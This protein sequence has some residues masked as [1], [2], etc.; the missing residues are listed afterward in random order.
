MHFYGGKATIIILRWNLFVS[1]VIMRAS[2]SEKKG[3]RNSTPRSTIWLSVIWYSYGYYF[4][5]ALTQG[6][7][8]I[9]MI[10]KE[11]VPLGVLKWYPFP[12]GYFFRPF[13]APKPIVAIVP[14]GH[15]FGTLFSLSACLE[16]NH[17][18]SYQDIVTCHLSGS[19]RLRWHA[20]R[21]RALI[22]HR[23]N[24]LNKPHQRRWGWCKPRNI[25]PGAQVV[26]GTHI[27][28][29]CLSFI[30]DENI[31]GVCADHAYALV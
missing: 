23:V 18:D 21:Q 27:H 24:M 28:Q 10:I 8:L 20:D 14:Q 26:I 6:Y 13:F 9:N 11:K 2:H 15:C 16:M 30:P 17:W 5:A 19:P 31:F 25:F 12:K 1:C 7:C 29:L 4:V 3:Y 22:V